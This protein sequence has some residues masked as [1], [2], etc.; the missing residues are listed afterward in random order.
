MP[1]GHF[2]F[3][4]VAGLAEAA[5]GSLMSAKDTWEGKRHGRSAGRL[6]GSLSK[7]PA[8]GSSVRVMVSAEENAG[9]GVRPARGT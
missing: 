1:L 8:P 6:E 3:A 4:W 7:V 5:R 2:L 9:A